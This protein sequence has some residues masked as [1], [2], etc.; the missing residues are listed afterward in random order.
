MKRAFVLTLI[1]LGLLICCAHAEVRVIVSIRSQRA[2]LVDGPG[3][4]HIVLTSVVSTARRGYTTPTGH[5]TILD[6]EVHHWSSL[7]GE[8]D[9]RGVYHPSPMFYYM[10]LGNFGLHWGYLPGYPASHGCIRMPRE[11]AMAFFARVHVGTSVRII[12][13]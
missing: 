4:G 8:R 1:V 13:N 11:G 6:K 9:A 5:F 12:P 10:R 7:Y 2:W 3:R